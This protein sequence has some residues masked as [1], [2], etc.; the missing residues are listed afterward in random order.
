MISFDV[1]GFRFN[2]RVSGIFVDSK[3]E[4]FLTNTVR[5]LDF[6]VLPGG[7]VDLGEDTKEALKREMME[8]LGK[9]IDIISLKIVSESF[10]EFE[11]RNYHE[12][13][14]IYVAKFKDTDL[15]KYDD[16]F[17]GFEEKD[18]YK[19]YKIEDFDKLSYKP[20]HLKKVIKEAMLGDLTFV[21]DIHR[22][23]G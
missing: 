11:G 20:A 1:D 23:N 7:R 4:R 9:E 21:H 15:E 18:V 8:E 3:N 5:K 19:W 22:G 13:Q 16:E 14:Y 12:L 10:F 17:D 2:Y 6:V